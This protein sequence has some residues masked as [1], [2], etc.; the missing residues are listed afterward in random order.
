[1]ASE[2]VSLWLVMLAACGVIIAVVGL[3]YILGKA[4]EG[5]AGMV[6]IACTFIWKALWKALMLFANAIDAIAVKIADFV[7]AKI[8]R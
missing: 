8:K 7:S 6:G 5:F 2:L 4:G 3:L 1:M